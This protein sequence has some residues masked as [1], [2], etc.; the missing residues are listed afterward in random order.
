MTI[1]FLLYLVFDHFCH[2][3]QT[4]YPCH[5]GLANNQLLISSL[6]SIEVVKPFYS[7]KEKDKC[8]E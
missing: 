4:Y 8:V 5:H 1:G 2:S 6:Q 3:G 7:L